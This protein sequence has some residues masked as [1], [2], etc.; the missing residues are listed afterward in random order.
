MAETDS[1]SLFRSE[2][3]AVSMYRV[4]LI[5][6]A[7]SLG[8]AAAC[9]GYRLWNPMAELG[10]SMS[11]PVGNS[12]LFS[13]L[14]ISSLVNLAGGV[15]LSMIFLSMRKITTLRIL[16]IAYIPGLFLL[17]AATIGVSQRYGAQGISLWGSTIGVSWML[18]FYAIL[19]AREAMVSKLVEGW[20]VVAGSIVLAVGFIVNFAQSSMVKVD[21]ETLSFGAS[22]TEPIMSLKFTFWAFAITAL[23]GLVLGLRKLMRPMSDDIIKGD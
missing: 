10:S 22:Q 6:S 17:I 4:G 14:F 15:G 11:I 3:W 23:V 12:A 2:K 16:Q 19:V 18:L 5:F 1:I 20:V 13:K 21:S 9:L 8:C 7:F